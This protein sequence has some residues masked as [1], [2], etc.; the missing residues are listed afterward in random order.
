MS[1]RY[2]LTCPPQTLEKRF[3]VDV[4]N[5]YKPI[6]NA[7]PTQLLPVITNED[8]KGFSFFYWGVTPKMAND[9]TI[10]AKLYNASSAELINKASYRNA[11]QSR[12]CIVP[13]DGYYEWK[14]IS[15]KGRTPYWIHMAGQVIFSLA[16]LWDEYE[17]GEGETHHTFRIITVPNNNLIDTPNPEMPAIL[18]EATEKDWLNTEA[19]IEDL[20]TLLKPFPADNMK[21]HS[22]SSKVNDP[23]VNSEDLIRHVPPADQ[24]GNYS[25][26]N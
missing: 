7:S 6:Y 18:E 9:K 10:S 11:L 2:T 25:L 12:R 19:S 26:F 8:K 23:Q 15:K 21:S 14:R 3:S 20:I 5:G 16:G 22:V 17:D 4:T 13:V 24:F 1:S